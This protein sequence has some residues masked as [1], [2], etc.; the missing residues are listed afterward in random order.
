MEFQN[1]QTAFSKQ[2]DRSPIQQKIIDRYQYPGSALEVDIENENANQ[3]VL[4]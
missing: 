4:T 2:T 3:N 1:G